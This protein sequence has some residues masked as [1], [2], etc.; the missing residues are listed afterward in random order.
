MFMQSFF[1]PI[2]F[3]LNSLLITSHV[4]I[5]VLLYNFT[6]FKT[7]NLVSWEDV[8]IKHILFTQ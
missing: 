6:V 7:I 5:S 4:A 8:L 1:S 2:V 3:N